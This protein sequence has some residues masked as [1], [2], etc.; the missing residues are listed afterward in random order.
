RH[1]APY[2]QIDVWR[3]T[4]ERAGDGQ[5]YELKLGSRLST[6]KETPSFKP[7]CCNLYGANIAYRMLR[8]EVDCISIVDWQESNEAVENA[9]L[10]RRCIRLLNPNECVRSMILFQRMLLLIHMRL[11]LRLES[12]SFRTGDSWHSYGGTGSSCLIT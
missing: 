3:V 1:A 6:F 2:T 12:T 7:G 10:Q 5:E 8:D 9:V 4:V 11:P